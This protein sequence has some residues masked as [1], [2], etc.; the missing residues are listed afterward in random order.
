MLRNRNHQNI[1]NEPSVDC[2]DLK[3][4]NTNKI[5]SIQVY[6]L[7]T[8]LKSLDQHNIMQSKNKLIIKPILNQANINDAIRKKNYKKKSQL[9]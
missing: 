9:S 6:I 3:K 7:N 4:K 8:I 1:W 2:W 5:K